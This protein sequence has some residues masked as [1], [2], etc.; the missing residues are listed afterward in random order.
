MISLEGGAHPCQ[1][2]DNIKHFLEVHHAIR[3]LE[4]HQQ[5]KYLT[6]EW[7]KWMFNK[8]LDLPCLLF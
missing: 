5:L 8:I 2:E 7:W 6:K 3:G 4:T 1:R